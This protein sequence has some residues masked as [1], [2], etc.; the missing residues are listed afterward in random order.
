MIGNSRVLHFFQSFFWRAPDPGVVCFAA[1]L[2][3][4]VLAIT[5]ELKNDNAR[6]LRWQ[7]ADQGYCLN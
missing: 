7:S 3:I 5:W 1:I 2:S 4:A 6:G